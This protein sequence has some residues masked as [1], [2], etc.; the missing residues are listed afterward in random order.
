MVAR[1]AHGLS[2]AAGSVA[3][4][5]E[6]VRF[7]WKPGESDVIHIDEFCLAVGKRVFV[8][9]RS[10]S[11]KSTLLSLLS[12]VV[13]PQ[14]G[15]VEILGRDLARLD[16]S[17]RDT[18]RGDHIGFIFQLF[19]LVPYLSVLDNVLLPCRFSAK[20]R[21][22]ARSLDGSIEKAARRLLNALELSASDLEHTAATDLSIGQQQ[23]VAAAR[24]LIGMPELIVADE[25]TS[26]L[27]E[28][29][30]ERFLE[31]LF[32]EC[33]LQKST[34]LFVSHDSRLERLFDNK[35]SLGEINRSQHQSA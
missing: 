5:L 16:R 31:L 28:D 22:R 23:R 17:T 9:G 8:A 14:S 25:P 18:F 34:L 35:I 3:V 30:Q 10:G 32:A 24:A 11:G 27:D 19:N 6:D 4:H 26:A 33:Q 15:K 2:A 1:A 20:R 21:A 13:Q 12:G 7:A 29:T